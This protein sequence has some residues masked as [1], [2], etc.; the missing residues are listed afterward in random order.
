MD[1]SKYLGFLH[2]LLI[3]EE[4][5][6]NR[7]T[8]KAFRSIQCEALASRII[9]QYIAGA[10]ACYPSLERRVGFLHDFLRLQRYSVSSI[11]Q[12]RGACYG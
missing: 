6:P 12:G 1:A 8:C 11:D 10:A 5:Q 3:V 2:N 7:V 9:A 4:T